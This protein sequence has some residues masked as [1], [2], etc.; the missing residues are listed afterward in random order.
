MKA[1]IENKDKYQLI[2]HN[3]DHAYADDVGKVSGTYM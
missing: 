1:L 3:G 2:I